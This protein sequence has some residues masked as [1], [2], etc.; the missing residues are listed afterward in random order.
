MYKRYWP[1]IFVPVAL[2]IGD[3]IDKSELR[4]MSDFANK[5]KLYGKP[6]KPE[7]NPWT[8]ILS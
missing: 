7:D 3:Y 4:R 1:L 8:P 6:R 5:S 2:Y